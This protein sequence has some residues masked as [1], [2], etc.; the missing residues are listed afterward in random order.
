MKLTVAFRNFA[1]AP[2]KESTHSRTDVDDGDGSA[3]LSSSVKKK[4]TSLY[5]KTTEL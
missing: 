2:K 5:N 1:N 3:A 4:G